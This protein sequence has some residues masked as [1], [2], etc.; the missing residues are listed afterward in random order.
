M[1]KD[2]TI[3]MQDS[4][5]RIAV[6]AINGASIDELTATGLTFSH[7]T[8]CVEDNSFEVA[9][10]D[11]E[12]GADAFLTAITKAEITL[13]KLLAQKDVDGL[14]QW[15]VSIDPNSSWAEWLADDSRVTVDSLRAAMLEAY[16]NED[17]H[18]WIQNNR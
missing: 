14:V 3:T 10:R 13:P 16:D 9:V 4:T 15:A 8:E 6:V 12:I 17:T 18:A 11:G 2:Y 7:A 1:T 5:G